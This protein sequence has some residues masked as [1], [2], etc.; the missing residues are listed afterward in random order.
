VKYL[1]LFSGIEAAS[2]AW[3]P[4]GFDPVA[5]A[6]IEPFPCAVLAKHFP[7][8]PNLGDVNDYREWPDMAVDLIVGGSPCQSFSVAGLRG[9]LADERGNL[10]LVFCR[11]VQRYK[12]RWVLW[13]NVPGAL[14]VERGA[15]FGSILSALDEIGYGLAWRV[16]DTQY[17][18]V[19][20]FPRAIPQRRKRLFLVGSLGDW[21]GAGAVLFDRES[22]RR[23]TPPRRRKENPAAGKLSRDARAPESRMIHETAWTLQACF[24]KKQGLED[25]HVRA[26]MPMFVP[27]AAR[28]LTRRGGRDAFGGNGVT[29]FTDPR[30]LRLRKLTPTEAERLQG[31]PDGW[32]AV[33]YR[34]RPACDSPRYAAL[35]NS[36]SVNVMRW[37]GERIQMVDEKMKELNNGNESGSDRGRA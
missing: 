29:I 28:G 37:L 34:G 4:L 26:G 3:E 24:G 6:E 1:S 25:Q 12:P 16:L 10:A 27:A 30:D 18:R 2:V 23:D 9:G 32:T 20:G 8:V 14:S 36:M 33:R 35:G 21:R 15:A 19:R 22:C 13:E 31:F 5:F 17:V 7:H 11:I